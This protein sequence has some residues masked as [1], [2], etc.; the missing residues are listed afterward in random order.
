M[1]EMVLDI[2]RD[3]IIGIISGAI[4]SLAVTALWQKHLNKIE[5]L[6][7]EQI[8]KKKSIDAFRNDVQVLCHFI[9]RLRLELELPQ[10]EDKNKNIRRIVDSRPITSTLTRSKLTDDGYNIICKLHN[11]LNNI[12]AD[13]IADSLS[14]NKCKKYNSKLFIIEMNLL[15]NQNLYQLI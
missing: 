2:I 14:D 9:D 5:K 6:K 4:S 8:E 11:C 12:D 3:I 7:E 10:D 15:K 13:A 1:N